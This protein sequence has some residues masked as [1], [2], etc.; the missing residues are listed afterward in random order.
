M[1]SQNTTAYLVSCSPNDP[2]L[3]PLSLFQPY[4]FATSF[5]EIYPGCI[6][7]MLIG[8]V[9]GDGAALLSSFPVQMN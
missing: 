6:Y 4:C 7:L 1:A 3:K 8:C 2:L 5:S 9:A